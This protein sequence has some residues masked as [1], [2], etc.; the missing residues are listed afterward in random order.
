MMSVS[1]LLSSL[2]AQKQNKKM[3]MNVDLL[4]FSL[5]A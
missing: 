4:S 1:S 5:G 2:G 3:M